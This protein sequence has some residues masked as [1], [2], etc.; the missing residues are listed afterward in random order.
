MT[1]KGFMLVLK[2]AVMRYYLSELNNGLQIR[3]DLASIT[4]IA[5]V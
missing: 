4:V 3:L 5:L 1:A 2:L